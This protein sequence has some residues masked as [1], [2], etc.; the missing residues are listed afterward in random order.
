MTDGI[1]FVEGPDG[2]PVIYKDASTKDRVERWTKAVGHDDMYHRVQEAML[3]ADK[4]QGDT[5]LMR[6]H[7]DEMREQVE[8]A[9]EM[10]RSAGIGVAEVDS[11]AARRVSVTAIMKQAVKSHDLDMLSK[12]VMKE[13]DRAELIAGMMVFARVEWARAV[14]EARALR[15]LVPRGAT[16][17]ESIMEGDAE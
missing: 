8:R 6:A 16:V 3:L 7:W 2:T 10:L 12:M 11:T 15:L 14:D 4:E 1:Y 9:E 17:A 13:F 5:E